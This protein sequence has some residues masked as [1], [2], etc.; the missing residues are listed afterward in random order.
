MPADNDQKGLGQ[1]APVHGAY[2]TGGEL[3]H[4][5]EG[6][7][8]AERLHLGE[9]FHP[10]NGGQQRLGPHGG[11]HLRVPGSRVIDLLLGGGQGLAGGA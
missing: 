5:E 9:V 6:G 3:A 7:L 4:E 1:D 2:E 11:N 10:L 8:V